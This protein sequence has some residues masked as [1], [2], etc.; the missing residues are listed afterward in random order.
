MINKGFTLM[1]VIIVIVILGI[2]AALAVRLVDTALDRSRFE[3][4]GKEME[5]LV[6]AVVGN[7]SLIQSGLRSDFGYVGDCAALPSS[8]DDLVTDPGVTGWNGPYISNEFTQDPDDFKTDAWGTEYNIKADGTITS[9][10]SDGAFGGTGYAEDITKVILDPIDNATKNSIKVYVRD[11]NGTTLT[12]IYVGVTIDDPG[13]VSYN[14]LYASGYFYLNGI[15]PIGNWKITATPTVGYIGKLGGALES[16]V[17]VYPR[18]PTPAPASVTKIRFAGTIAEI[19]KEYRAGQVEVTSAG[20]AANV[21]FTAVGGPF[22]VVLT[23]RTGPAKAFRLRVTATDD[24]NYDDFDLIVENTKGQAV[25]CSSTSAVID[26]I[27]IE[28]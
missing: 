24:T 26:Y 28:R 2:L 17:S 18:G 10:G 15:V 16:I 12:N 3:A 25:N 19:Y 5:H 11:G 21:T 8:L 9:Y 1:E 14:L 27:V 4:T 7:P 6:F 20:G 23:L 22:S 13:G